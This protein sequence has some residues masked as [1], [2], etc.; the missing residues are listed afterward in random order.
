MQNKSVLLVGFLMSWF[1]LGA[2]NVQVNARMDSTYMMIGDQT[3]IHLEYTQDKNSNVIPLIPRDTLTKGVE[4][5]DLLPT[6][7]IDLGNNRVTVTQDLLITSFDSA[8]YYLPPIKFAVGEDTLYSNPLAL[9]VMTYD[10]DTESKQI[11][12]I[13]DIKP[14]KFV[15]MDYIWILITILIIIAVIVAGYFLYKRYFNKGNVYNEEKDK[16]TL[17]PH[18]IAEQALEDLRQKKLW[19]QGLEKE[20]YTALTD[21]LRDYI[22]GRF[23]INAMEMTSSEIIYDLKKLSVDKDSINTLNKL[24]E[25][26]DFVKFAKLKPTMDENETSI[27]TAKNFVVDTEPVEEVNEE[28]ESS[29]IE[30]NEQTDNNKKEN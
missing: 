22:D 23:G 21:I 2:Q 28:D 24:L 18:V 27:L 16:V 20:Y 5:L 14:A 4:I 10:V 6:D 3:K 17:P 12:D 26:S 30:N 7:T 11:Y 13:K 9:K 8:L 29:D 15:L 19:Q 25:L 1:S